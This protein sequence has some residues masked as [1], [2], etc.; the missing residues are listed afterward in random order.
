[1]V[2]TKDSIAE[3]NQSINTNFHDEKGSEPQLVEIKDNTVEAPKINMLACSSKLID[4]EKDN[5]ANIF[6]NNEND[7]RNFTETYFKIPDDKKF[8]V[9]KYSSL[10]TSYDDRHRS[11]FHS[12]RYDQS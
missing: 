7:V 6:E 9:V 1:M 12:E 4:A 10:R 3:V 11:T 5:A 8:E 2:A